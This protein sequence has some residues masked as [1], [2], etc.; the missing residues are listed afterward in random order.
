MTTLILIQFLGIYWM[1]SG[2]FSIVGIFVNKEMWGWK[3]FSGILGIIAGIVVLQ[4]P[5]WSTIMIP[6]VLVVLLGVQGFI[7]GSIGIFQ[8]FKG[9]GWGAGILGFLSMLFGLLLLFNPFLGALILPWV[10]GVIS[11]IGGIVATI[12]AFRLR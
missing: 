9:G 5:L 10:Y 6:T 7:I 8:A 1:V 3:L 4:H 2:I 11:I 12:Y